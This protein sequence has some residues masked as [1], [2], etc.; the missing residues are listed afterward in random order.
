M[1]GD[2]SNR[3]SIFGRCSALRNTFRGTAAA[4]WSTW[5]RPGIGRRLV[6]VRTRD[7]RLGETYLVEVPQRLPADRYPKDVL[8]MGLWWRL[9][10][11]RGCRFRVVVTKVD[12]TAM[13]PMVE[14]LRKVPREFIRLDLSVEQVAELGLPPGTYSLQGVLYDSNQR[15]AELPEVEPLR[16]PVRWLHPADAERSPYSHRDVDYDPW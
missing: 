4:A 11:L 1:V 5:R 14:G 3:C 7:V 13:P 12:E 10:W 9:D 15:P 8:G 2:M 16:V 6:D